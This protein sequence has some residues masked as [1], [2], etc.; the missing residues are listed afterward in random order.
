MK[1]LLVLEGSPRRRGNSGALA[2]VLCASLKDWQIQRV[3]VSTK[4]I[5]GCL[6]CDR[7]WS[8][9]GQPCVQGDDMNAL[10]LEIEAADVVAFVTPMYYF[11]FPTQL[12]AVIDRL[13]PYCKDNRPRSISGKRC[14]LL[15][16]GATDDPEEFHPLLENY[17]VLARYLEWEDMGALAAHGVYERGAIEGT[18]W[19]G[20]AEALAEMLNAKLL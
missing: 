10:C 2:D 20:Q 8:R 15:A 11:G 14:L 3:A 12:K 18:S 7:C 19:L 17:R 6:A 1:R 13:Y 16:C 5:G 9:D 4:K